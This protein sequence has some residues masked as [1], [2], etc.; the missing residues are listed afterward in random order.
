MNV[1][2][3]VDMDAFYA[4]V[5][6]HD[7]PAYQG[8][9]VVVGALPGHRGVV[10]ACSYEAR[11]YGIHSA[12]PISE[13]YKLCPRAIYLPVRMERYQELSSRIMQ[14]LSRFTP[15]LQQMSVDEA[16]LDLS[17]TE[18]LLGP[19]AQIARRIKEMVCEQTGL[20]ISIGVA[21]SRYLAKLASERNKPDGL[22]IVEPGQEAE[23]VA[24]LPLRKLWGIGK[25]TLGRLNSAGIH[26]VSGLRNHSRAEL[27][28]LLG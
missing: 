27:T 19:P 17:G 14:I 1:F 8:K 18:R 11:T 23:F 13:A 6:Q 5:E 25:K 22:Y 24:A 15:D 28:E 20:T 9:P 26:T 10:S 16:F 4:S 2:M 3:H 21:P 12:M 7:N